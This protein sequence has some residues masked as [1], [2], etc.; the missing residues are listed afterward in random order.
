M[1]VSTWLPFTIVLL[2]A[3]YAI[4]KCLQS[5]RAIMTK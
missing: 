3:C 5:E 4:L 1:A 2:G